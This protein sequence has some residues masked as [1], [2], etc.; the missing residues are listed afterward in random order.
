MICRI[1]YFEFAKLIQWNLRKPKI[2]KKSFY[3]PS[4][5]IFVA[6]LVRIFE[7]YKENPLIKAKIQMLSP[8]HFFAAFVVQALI[9]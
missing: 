8:L 7:S 3:Y 9:F 1:I 6:Y 4:H 5:W 2:K